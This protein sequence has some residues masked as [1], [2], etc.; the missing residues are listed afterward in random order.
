MMLNYRLKQRDGVKKPDV[1]LTEDEIAYLVRKTYDLSTAMNRAKQ[2]SL[3]MFVLA[4]FT[5]ARFKDIRHIVK[6][7]DAAGNPVLLYHN[8]K[9]TR[10]QTVAWNPAVEGALKRGLYKT[11][12]TGSVMCAAL[13]VALWEALPSSSNRLIS[14]YY[15]RPGVGRELKTDNR[16]SHITFHA[17]RHTF[18]TRLLRIGISPSIVAQLAGHKSI[19]TTMKYYN[20]TKEQEA[21]DILRSAYGAESVV[22]KKPEWGEG[23]KVKPLPKEI[24]AALLPQPQ[25]GPV[26]P[27]D[28]G[29]LAKHLAVHP[30][31]KPSA[32][33]LAWRERLRE[34]KSKG[35]GT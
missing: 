11:L 18:C 20:W 33:Q 15:L 30:K 1:I 13:K 26:A 16:I 22:T 14:Y 25:Q 5:A 4:L 3:D 27:D 28:G 35:L 2:K 7:T 17:A 31:R 24:H 29:L 23:A 8:S 12:G 9:G 10:S 19:Q 6:S 32:K 21:N 34:L